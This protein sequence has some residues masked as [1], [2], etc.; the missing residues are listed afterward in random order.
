[1][2]DVDL[3]DADLVRCGISQPGSLLLA[4]WCNRLIHA[5][6]PLELSDRLAILDMGET[7]RAA[8]WV[9]SRG[10]RRLRRGGG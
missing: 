6:G 1:M 3:S 7:L 10:K 9:R 8:G 4:I 2:A 5:R